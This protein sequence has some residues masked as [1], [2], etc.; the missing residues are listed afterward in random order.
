MN[1]RLIHAFLTE[2]KSHNNRDW[3]Q[4]N[5]KQYEMARNEVTDILNIVIPG[6]RKFDPEIGSPAPKDCLFRIYRDVRF[7]KDKS[8]YKTNFGAFI[9]RGGRKG[10]YAGYYFH[11][12]PGNSF[13]GGGIYMPPSQVLKSVRREVLYHADELKKIIEDKTF[14]QNFGGLQGDK[15]VRPPKDFP[16]DFK[17]MELLKYKDYLAMQAV[18][19]DL[20]LSDHY[21]DHMLK[22]FQ[23]MK[24]LNQFLNRAIDMTEN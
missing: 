10:N 3:F 5:K 18:D 2:L 1:T 20:L 16:K 12:E 17:D 24:P 7:S 23:A 4:A 21:V 19:D 6:I 14:R 22:V 9:A 13:F 15:L 11:I 8:P